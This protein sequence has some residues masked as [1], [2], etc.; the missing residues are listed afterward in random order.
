MWR[1]RAL[2]SRDCD[3][4]S[5]IHYAAIN[6][7]KLQLSV[8]LSKKH[9]GRFIARDI[10]SAKP[11]DEAQKN[12]HLTSNAK[13]KMKVS[14]GEAEKDLMLRH[15]VYNTLTGEEVGKIGS[16]MFNIDS[17]YLSSSNTYL[18]NLYLY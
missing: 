17:I 14:E 3:G 6:G 8:M 9:R 12:K 15:V 11:S 13:R 18:L 4:R 1:L 10:L 2:G 5:P 16:G 7:S